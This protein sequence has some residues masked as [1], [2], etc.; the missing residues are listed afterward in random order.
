MFSTTAN[1]NSVK[2]ISIHCAFTC[3]CIP[4]I[5]LLLYYTNNLFNIGKYHTVYVSAVI[6]LAEIIKFLSSSLTFSKD[7]KNLNKSC[8]KLKL[9]EI[10]KTIMVIVTSII[11]FYLIA[12]LFGAPLITKCEE[13]LMLSVL[14]SS[15][16]VIPSC[17]NVG[18]DETIC[19]LMGRPTNVN[20]VNDMIVRYIQFTCLGTWAGAIVIPLDWN[21]PW[22]EWPVP[23][24]LGAFTGYTL[25]HVVTFI[26]LLPHIFK[27][28]TGRSFRFSKSKCSL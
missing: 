3:V 11:I 23:C 20:L 2:I 15:L 24:S 10:F 12:V 14:V 9:K 18:A 22:Q 4:F 27:K 1:S 7:N 21:R 8:S 6:I 13:T 25:A 5:L 19:L 17:L 28:Y 16:T 26:K